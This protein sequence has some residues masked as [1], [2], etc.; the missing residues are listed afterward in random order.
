LLICKVINF[1]IDDKIDAAAEAN[2]ILA[3]KVNKKYRIKFFYTKPL[4]E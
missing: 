1:Y 3:A 2:A 4:P